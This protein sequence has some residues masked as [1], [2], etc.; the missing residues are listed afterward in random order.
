[1]GLEKSKIT[2]K[3]LLEDY[4]KKNLLAAQ[5]VLLASPSFYFMWHLIHGTSI[6]MSLIR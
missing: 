5:N 1:V 2:D 6:N 3:Q 4:F